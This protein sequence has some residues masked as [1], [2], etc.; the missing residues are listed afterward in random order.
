MYRR[1]KRLLPFLL[2]ALL[3]PLLGPDSAFTQMQGKGKRGGK[4]RIDT[5]F[6][7]FSGGRDTFDVATV[8][9]PPQALQRDTE[10]N[11]R[12]RWQT[13]LKK[14]G[15]TNGIMTRE[16][17]RVYLSE[18]TPDQATQTATPIG[19]V[20][21][22]SMPVEEKRPTVYRM[23]K[24]PKDL[25]AWFDQYDKDRDGQIGLY[26]WK[27]NGLPIAEFLAMDQNGDGFVTAEEVLRYQKAQKKKGIPAGSPP[28]GGK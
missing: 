6:N 13:F 9:I 18:L 26:E 1:T 10:E 28:T 20:A 2:L 16:L 5:L 17:F 24:L 22:P 14:K 23:G 7:Q 3:L 21:P 12:E 8:P 27:A 19:G 11:K 25:P 15:V 4:N